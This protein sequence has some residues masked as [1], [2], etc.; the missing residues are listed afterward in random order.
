MQSKQ[1]SYDY[2]IKSNLL[3]LSLFHIQ[4]LF[5]KNFLVGFSVSWEPRSRFSHVNYY[6]IKP[7]SLYSL[8]PFA[9]LAG[10][11]HGVC[12]HREPRKLL[13]GLR[14]GFTINGP[15]ITER[16]Q[17]G[18]WNETMVKA[19]I[20]TW[21]SVN[22]TS[23]WRATQ[24]GNLFI[25]ILHDEILHMG[26]RILIMCWLFSQLLSQS[27]ENIHQVLKISIQDYKLVC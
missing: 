10:L 4:T 25:V 11:Q 2:L 7:F 23:F 12:V 19:P 17:R 18:C 14:L 15:L 8:P 21:L 13:N 16:T 6:I 20:R 22:C 5:W 24:Q 9:C 1:D 26:N 27:L 3:G